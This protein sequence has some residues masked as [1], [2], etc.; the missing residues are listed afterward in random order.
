[1][2]QKNTTTRRHFLK[3]SGSAT[4][5]AAFPAIIPASA[6]GRGG[7]I[8]P[9]ERIVMGGIGMGQMFEHVFDHHYRAIHEHAN[10]HGN[11]A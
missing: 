11:T 9:S 3:A 4:L 2:N 10:C 1:M 5:A 7:A 6:L 8:A